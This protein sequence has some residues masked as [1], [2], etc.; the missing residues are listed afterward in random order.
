MSRGE[1]D[2]P[3]DAPMAPGISTKAQG[4]AL[5]RAMPDLIFRCSRDGRI[6]D[7]HAPDGA[8]L[9]RT[10]G[11][12]LGKHFEDILPPDVAKLSSEQLEICLGAGQ[13][14]T[15][16]YPLTIGG[17]ERHFEARMVASGPD[18]A[19]VVVRDVTSQKRT[20]AAL[21]E[22]ETRYRMLA[23][24]TFDI[25]WR[26]DRD[27][28][29]NY[30]SPSAELHFGYAPA[31]VLEMRLSDLIRPED[32]S[33]I[34]E[35]VARRM[36]P[37]PPDAGSEPPIR[38]EIEHRRKNGGFQWA[39]IITTPIRD[40]QGNLTGYQGVTR[41]ISDR[42]EAEESLRLSEEQWRSLAEDSPDYIVTLDAE[43]HI[44]FANRLFPGLLREKVI[45]HS[46]FD[47]IP[48]DTRPALQ[49][50]F[51]SAMASGEPGRIEV[52]TT[53]PGGTLT[54]FEARYRPVVRKGKAIAMMLT[55]TDITERRQAEETLRKTAHRLETFHE[56]DRAILQARSPEEVSNAALAR[57]TQL[58]RCTGAAVFS[59]DPAEGAARVT[60]L[61]PA[62]ESAPFA[63]IVLPFERLPFYDTLRNGEF[64][65]I[66]DIMQ[67]DL[68]ARVRVLFERLGLYAVIAIPLAAGKGEV[69]GALCL[70]AERAAAFSLEDVAIVQDIADSLAIALRQAELYRRIQQDAQ[71][72]EL[73]LRE[74]N[75]RVKNN[76]SAIIGMLYAERGRIKD[77]GREAHKA[78]LDSLANRVQGLATVHSLLSTAEWRPLLLHELCERIVHGVFQGIPAGKRAL[79]EIAPAR[80]RAGS[81]QA[82]HLAIV[83]NELAGNVVKHVLDKQDL[84]HIVIQIAESGNEVRIVF[85]DDGPGYP[86]DMLEKGASSA[87]AG[88]EL[89]RSLVERNLGGTLTLRSEGGAHAEMA[90]ADGLESGEAST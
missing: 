81:N 72:K 17:E 26:M 45:G 60:A 80:V 71:T 44:L 11:E 68:S 75:H 52:S 57:I 40:E 64:S 38:F 1:S 79:L 66:E 5:L 82:H 70:G 3:P 85:S 67:Q 10:P 2:A 56:I 13:P 47:Y 65:V 22:S 21:R 24:N 34:A 49:Q 89:A 84:A 88:I 37:H 35:R 12:F 54:H 14:R 4:Q 32:F 76:L 51:Q 87:G 73:L 20:E 16:D 7:F 6:I 25:I 58:V 27:L 31:E 18:E 8:M 29:F 55:A 61:Y 78:L 69:I 59:F 77:A 39:E 15:Y 62:R 42:K 90:F 41:N 63:G 23:E 30:V 36:R 19:L 33:G 46:A 86:E 48:E 43:A 74:M 28:K 9:Y 50:F 53:Q 83:F